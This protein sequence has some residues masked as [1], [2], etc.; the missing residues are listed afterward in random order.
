MTPNHSEDAGDAMP[1][2]KP[3][4]GIRRGYLVQENVSE[5]LR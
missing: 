5:G 3:N 1:N 2:L 4:A